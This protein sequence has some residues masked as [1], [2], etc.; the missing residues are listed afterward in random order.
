MS[1]PNRPK[2]QGAR[3]GHEPGDGASPP[4][5][6]PKQKVEEEDVFGGAERNGNERVRESKP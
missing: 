5:K 1:T 6:K 4:P 3:T 2:Q